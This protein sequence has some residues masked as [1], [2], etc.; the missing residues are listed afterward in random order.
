LFLQAVANGVVLGSLFALLAVGLTLTYGVMEVPNFA[1]AGV[2]TLAAYTMLWLNQSAGWP[3]WPA[4]AG[5]LVVGGIISVLTE[6]IAYRFVRTRPLAAPVVALG[7]LLVLD[8]TALILFG[9][10]HVSLSPPYAGDVLYIGTATVP[11]VGVALIATTAVA[12]L[13]LHLVLQRTRTGRAIR[14]VAQNAEAAATLGIRLERQ[15][16]I[17]FFISGILAGLAAFAYAPMYAVFP[18]MADAILLNAF[19]VVVLG[20]LGNVGGAAVC[21]LFLGLLESFG[22]VYVSAAYQTLFGFAVLLLMI[23]LRP[24]GLFTKGSRRVA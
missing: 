22:A 3:F 5:G 21:G 19:V 16:V 1:Q 18:Y 6:R 10:D 24:S 17:S 4:V 14:A 2:I 23:V 13:I 20:G 12:L 8:N 15:Y 11:A 7:M 9:G